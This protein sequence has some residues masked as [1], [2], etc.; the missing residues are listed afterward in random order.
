MNPELE[1][2]LESILEP[3]EPISPDVGRLVV[4]PDYEMAAR[5]EDR[6]ALKRELLECVRDEAPGSEIVPAAKYPILRR[7][8]RKIS[9]RADRVEGPWVEVAPPGNWI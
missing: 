8:I 5:E 2:F 3:I 6:E 4:E 7:Y 9:V 1:F